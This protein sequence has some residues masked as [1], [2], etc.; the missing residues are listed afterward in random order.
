M[1]IQKGSVIFYKIFISISTFQ[2]FY[3]IK[4]HLWDEAYKTFIIPYLE[5]ISCKAYSIYANF[6]ALTLTINVP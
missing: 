1:L 4:I 2:C 3:R 6:V 5:T